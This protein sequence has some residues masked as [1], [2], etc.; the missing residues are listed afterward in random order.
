MTMRQIVSQLES[1]GHKVKYTIRK[2]G[3][4]RITKI[5]GKRFTGSQGNT[6]AREMAGQVLSTRREAQLKTIRSQ[7]GQFGHRKRVQQLPEQIIKRIRR[8]Q[9]KFRKNNVNRTGIVT[10][11]NYRYVL[12][13]YGQEEAERRL[14]QA[15]RYASGL[16]YTENVDALTKRLE[17]DLDKKRSSKMENIKNRISAMRENFKE[18][19][20]NKI[21]EIIYEWEQGRI[22]G[23]EA[24]DAIARILSV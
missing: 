17:L 2:D 5:N 9:A 4:I 13:T 7:K 1:Q 16:A 24:A 22:S 10:Q 18:S 19:W 12:K 15:E 20:I 23:D 8:V 21:Y 11:R 14:A 6:I 3:G